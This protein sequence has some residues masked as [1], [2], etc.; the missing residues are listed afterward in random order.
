MRFCI[1][2]LSSGS[3][4]ADHSTSLL[5]VL[6]FLGDE[7]LLLLDASDPSLDILVAM[8]SV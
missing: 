3:V 4:T 8:S 1:R 2:L 5:P 7:G 6:A